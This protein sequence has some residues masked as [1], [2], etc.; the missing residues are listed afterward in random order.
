MARLAALLVLLLGLSNPAIEAQT[1]PVHAPDGDSGVNFIASIFVPA[2][3]NAPF[4][5][6]V[7]TEETRY[8]PNGATVVTT[9]HRLIARDGQGRVFQ[10]RRVFVRAGSPLDSQLS[11]TEI[12]DP[13]T[14]TVASCD[15][16]AHV[17]ELRLYRAT[18]TWTLPA[19]GRSANGASDLTREDL[20]T[21]TV[22]GLELIGT[23]E[24]LTLDGDQASTV[25]V[26]KD[27]WY[28]PQLGVNVSTK[29][30]DARIRRIE[31][32]T[33]TDI[34]LSEPDPAL[35]TLP[36]DARVVDYRPTASP[37]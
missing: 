17:C 30:W 24:T 8:L 29:R 16:D 7:N 10:E 1:Q 20:G 23:R 36:A 31:Q 33:V 32:F 12:A 35:F 27:F 37:R 21:Q 25:S 14:R 5:A 22:D 9:N 13:T 4:S 11:R 28:S 19:P 26:T 3:R 2:F 15:P 6:T 18:T 34:N